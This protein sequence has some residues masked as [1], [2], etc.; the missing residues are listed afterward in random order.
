MFGRVVLAVVWA[1][2]AR[3]AGT[4]ESTARRVGP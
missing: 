1:A 2:A 4:E 3:D